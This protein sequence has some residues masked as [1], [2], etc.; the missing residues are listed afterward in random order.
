MTENLHSRVEDSFSALLEDDLPPEQKAMVEQHLAVCIQCRTGLERFR[1]TVGKL[2]ALRT[3]APRTFL[4]DIQRQIYK[5]SRGRFFGRRWVL[6]GRI[7]FEWASLL[8]IIAMLVYYVITQQAAPS[9]VT[10]GP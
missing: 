7:P 10:P 8:M 9:H 2:G 3:K 4:P 1:A 5:R 6:F